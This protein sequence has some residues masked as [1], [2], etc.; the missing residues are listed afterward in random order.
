MPFLERINAP[1]VASNLDISEEPRLQGLFKQS[2]IIARGSRKIG[3]IGLVTTETEHSSYPDKVKF[4]DIAATVQRVSPALR[5]AGAD[6]IIVLSHCGLAMDKRLVLAVGEHLDIVV[7]GHSHSLLYTGE[8][9]SADYPADEYPLVYEKF[10]RK[11]LIVQALAYS[12][13]VGHLK[14]T[15]NEANEIVHYEGNPIFMAA[16]VPKDPEVEAALQPWKVEVD[17]I[18]EV[19][20]GRSLIGLDKQLCNSGECSFGNLITDA[21][22]DFVSFGPTVI[23]KFEK[24]PLK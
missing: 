16:N 12:K 14:V 15:F 23:L 8:V 24:K 5:A 10:G 1:I 21:Y 2:L 3:I 17:R 7:G 11:K 13:Y 4:L 19:P 20:I 18:G 22:V 9:P 6:I